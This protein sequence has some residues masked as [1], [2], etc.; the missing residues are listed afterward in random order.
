MFKLRAVSAGLVAA[1]LLVA[2]VSPAFADRGDGYS[3]GTY[4]SVGYYGGYRGYYPGG[5]RAGY[6]YGGYRGGYYYGG[7]RGGYYGPG[8]WGAGI[9]WPAAVVSLKPMPR[10][11][12]M[13]IQCYAGVSH[14]IVRAQP[15]LASDQISAIQ[16]QLSQR[17]LPARRKPSIDLFDR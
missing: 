13:T 1:A 4:Q 8:Y 2:P 10:C 12:N 9:W 17:F 6:Y 15:A 5:Y 11:E 14:F 7:Y 3:G 16:P